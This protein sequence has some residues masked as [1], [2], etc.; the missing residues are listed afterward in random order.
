MADH[1]GGGA[2][3]P[4]WAHGLNY[5][6]TYI[7]ILM[8][9]FLKMALKP[10]YNGNCGGDMTNLQKYHKTFLNKYFGGLWVGVQVYV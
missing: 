8:V 4:L 6:I 9:A 7:P 5:T 2:W 1:G 3:G 10:V